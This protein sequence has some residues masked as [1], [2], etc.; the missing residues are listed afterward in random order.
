MN[1]TTNKIMDF[2]LA[3][4]LAG[5]I[6]AAI[7]LIVYATAIMHEQ[8]PSRE[9]PAP[10]MSPARMTPVSRANC[11]PDGVAITSTQAL[12][13][14]VTQLDMTLRNGRDVLGQRRNPQQVREMADA[15]AVEFTA[16]DVMLEMLSIC[17]ADLQDTNQHGYWLLSS[18][19]TRAAVAKRQTAPMFA[20][21]AP[22]GA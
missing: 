17:A 11:A 5:A 21:R 13:Y 20:P 6:V 16:P 15:I 2:T 14:A 7:V 8:H 1:R 4:M 12:R 10:A 22:K 9:V 19:L 18:A 3:I